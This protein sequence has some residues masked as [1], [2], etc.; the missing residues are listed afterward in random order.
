MTV[1]GLRYTVQASGDI[2]NPRGDFCSSVSAAP[3]SSS[4]NI[5]MYGG[6][7]VTKGRTFQSIYILSVPSFQWI[8]VNGTGDDDDPASAV[9][10]SHMT[11]HLYQER[12][13]IVLGGRW[14][15][16]GNTLNEASCNVAYPSVRVLD[17]S[18]LLWN[19]N[20]SGKAR[21]YEVPQ[22]V[23]TRIGGKYV[24]SRLRQYESWLM[25]NSATG[26]ATARQP[27]GGFNDSLNLVF[28]QTVPSS[29][30]VTSITPNANNGTTNTTSAS[31][32][33][34]PAG[35]IAGGVVGGVVAIAGAVALVFWLRRRQRRS[36]LE[37]LED[38]QKP[39]LAGDG[40]NVT[41][42]A[43]SW[44]PNGRQLAEAEGDV[45]QVSDSMKIPPDERLELHELGPGDRADRGP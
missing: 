44:D 43:L 26:G 27:Q 34:T 12:Q 37:Q 29:A 25:H 45:T 41:T 5:V 11:C 22:V 36:R 24:L 35:A 23:Y 31:S 30:P 42:P 15:R 19:A 6:W 21:P 14:M 28:A 17:T 13:M 8:R 18:D 10:H 39:E 32:S 16:G 7:S 38:W 33:S 2:P 40:P 4:F 3:D 9:G 1:H 20:W